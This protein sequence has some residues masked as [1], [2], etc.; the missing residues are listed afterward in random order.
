[1]P[2]TR[3]ADEAGAVMRCARLAKH[4]QTAMTA[5]RKSHEIAEVFDVAREEAI[6]AIVDLAPLLTADQRE[7]LRPILAG[8]LPVDVGRADSA[9]A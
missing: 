5:G 1:M 7:Q 8:S 9:A 2:Q 6:R 3:P 4:V